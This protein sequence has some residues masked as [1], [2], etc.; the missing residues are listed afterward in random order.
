M[1]MRPMTLG[2]ALRWSPVGGNAVIQPCHQRSTRSDHRI[3]K[4]LILEALPIARRSEPYSEKHLPG[5]LISA[6]EYAVQSGSW[7]RWILGKSYYSY[8]YSSSIIISFTLAWNIS[9][10]KSRLIADRLDPSALYGMISSQHM[11]LLS[12]PNWILKLYSVS[13][14]VLSSFLRDS[15]SLCPSVGLELTSQIII[16]TPL[17]YQPLLRT[18]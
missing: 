17:F 10:Y 16:G 14:S 9:H 15:L 11:R 18:M 2:K 8:S 7:R 5:G 3:L 4:P 1:K 6:W 13:L 12:S